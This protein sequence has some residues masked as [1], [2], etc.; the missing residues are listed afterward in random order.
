VTTRRSPIHPVTRPL[1][2][3]LRICLWF[4][5]AIVGSLLFFIRLLD[6]GIPWDSTPIG[7]VAAGL[8][9]GLAAPVWHYQCAHNTGSM[10]FGVLLYP[11]YAWCGSSYLW[12]KLLSAL[13]LFGGVMF[14]A[15]AMGR[16]G[17]PKLQLLFV[18]WAI[19]PPPFLEKCYH[20][21]VAIHVE[22]LF[23]LGLL[24]HLF[25]RMPTVGPRFRE[26][27]VFGFVAGFA[28]F[29]SPE[30]L[31]FVAAAASVAVARWR[32]RRVVRVLWPGALGFAVGL[33][34]LLMS[35]MYALTIDHTQQG[36][37]A[38]LAFCAARWWNLGARILP[39]FAG[40]HGFAGRPLTLAWPL[41]IAAGAAVVL[42]EAAAKKT[43]MA[44]PEWA[45]LLIVLHVVFFCGALGFSA[46]DIDRTN[47]RY[48]VT[49]SL[50]FYSLASFFL[51]RLRPYQKW[52]LLAPFLLS[53]FANL[54]SRGDTML[55]R[56]PHAYQVLVDEWR[57]DRAHRG[58]DYLGRLIGNDLPDRWTSRDEAF[59]EAAKLPCRWR[60]EAYVAIGYRLAPEDFAA[61]AR[62]ETQAQFARQYV[63][64][65]QGLRLF[66]YFSKTGR[67]PALES[68]TQTESDA[69]SIRQFEKNI[70][71][72]AA[73]G[74][75][76][77]FPDWEFA[78]AVSA[79]GAALHR[80]ALARVAEISALFPQLTHREF[81]LAFLRGVGFAFGCR[82]VPSIECL[83]RSDDGEIRR[84]LSLAD[85]IFPDR[86]DPEQQDTFRAGFVDGLATRIMTSVNRFSF[87]WQAIDYATLR[88]ALA[89][90]GVL[91]R[92]VPG[93]ADEFDLVITPCASP[94]VAGAAAS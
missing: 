1:S 8:A 74:F 13:F 19:L 83:H 26:S 64:I 69:T 5:L 16:V 77:G 42:R 57:R 14:W 6:A 32:G 15:L 20:E 55:Y 78:R 73:S 67:P 39:H 4:L 52:L 41:L 33:S 7:N 28:V 11:V 94:G 37:V 53:G 70:A 31:P 48:L 91:C 35:P 40:Y 59:A 86:D 56:A 58:D 22:S 21:V 89:A 43:E 93:H 2:R 88:D 18:L 82:R 60:P 46:R 34:P 72:A 65:G 27:L 85:P 9:E 61:F 17:G 24:L 29:F 75:G 68:T 84:A 90:H 51:L 36:A 47:P 54:A 81:S 62:D 92:P 25:T 10:L 71:L 63:A 38:R 12:L 45:K 87:N 76:R 23:F 50:S 30:N 44:G 80:E 79:D 49:L 3:R 66:L